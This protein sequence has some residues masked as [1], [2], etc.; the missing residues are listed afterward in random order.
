MKYLLS[1]MVLGVSFVVG[2][3]WPGAIALESPFH[4]SQITESVEGSWQLVGWGDPDN[5]TP[6]VDGTEVTAVFEGDRLGGSGGCNR[7]TSTYTSTDGTLKIGPTA[8]TRRAC[9]SPVGEQEFQYFRALEGVETYRITE[10]GQLELA[11][12]TEAGGGV[13]LFSR[14]A[15]PALW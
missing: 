3:T 6:P 8:A 7:Y 11:Y 12:E 15:I 13:L 1:S 5:L 4:L 9:Q 14:A 10:D 2:G